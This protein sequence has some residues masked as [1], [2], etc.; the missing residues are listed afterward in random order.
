MTSWSV[1]SG[2]LASSWWQNK[3]L[4]MIAFDTPTAVHISSVA[5]LFRL[6]VDTSRPFSARVIVASS[7]LNWNFCAFFKTLADLQIV[8]ST[9]CE[10]LTWTKRNQ[11]LKYGMC[12]NR[13][14]EKLTRNLTWPN[15]SAMWRM[16]GLLMKPMPDLQFGGVSPVNAYLIHSM[17]VVFPLPFWP[18]IS[19]NGEPN[20]IFYN[21][22]IFH[23]IST[24]SKYSKQ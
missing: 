9:P 4:L 5:S 3:T 20:M 18:R 23:E 6:L 15:D 7:D 24:Q 19:V 21:T 10:F 1:P 8:T 17:I 22:Q 2:Q 11:L 13:V 14:W 16:S 12:V